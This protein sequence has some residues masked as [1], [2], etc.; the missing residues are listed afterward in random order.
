MYLRQALQAPERLALFWRQ[1]MQLLVS[2]VQP[3]RLRWVRKPLPAMQMST[4]QG[5]PAQERSAHSPSRELLT[6]PLLASRARARLA[7]LHPVE[8]L[9][10]LLQDLQELALSARSLPQAAR[11][12]RSQGLQALALSE[13]L[14]QPALRM[15]V[16][17]GFRVL[18]Q[19]ARLRSQQR[20][21]LRSPDLPEQ[22]RSQASLSG[23]LSTRIKTQN[24]VE[25]QHHKRLRGRR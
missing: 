19:L 11:Q 6:L 20:R 9:M 4:R 18:E 5:L 1:A 7:R 25:S 17:L 22:E 23:D 24:G 21:T 16:L 8:W 10:Y 2:A 13:R 15:S 12:L 14:L 3:P